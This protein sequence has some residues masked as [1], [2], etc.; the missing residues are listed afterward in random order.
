MMPTDKALWT[1]SL[2]EGAV[3]GSV[4]SVLSMSTG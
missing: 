1:Q 2:R 3:A 4:A